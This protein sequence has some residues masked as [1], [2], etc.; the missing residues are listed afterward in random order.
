MRGIIL[1]KA[2]PGQENE[3]YKKIENRK[4]DSSGNWLT[5]DSTESDN[6][7]RYQLF[8]G[9]YDV[10]IEME[11]NQINEIGE[12]V[13]KFRNLLKDYIIETVTLIEV[14]K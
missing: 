8:Y 12:E 13:I 5:S 14:R 4:Q 7:K 3:I 11:C 9:P 2:K 10:V 1:I 6:I